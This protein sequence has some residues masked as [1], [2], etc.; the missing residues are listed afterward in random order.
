MQT[1]GVVLAL[2]CIIPGVVFFFL[3]IWLR[4]SPEFADVAWGPIIAGPALVFL[5]VYIF[6]RSR[7][8]SQPKD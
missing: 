4:S 6:M 5:G 3:G 1:Q 2:R 7:S 8:G